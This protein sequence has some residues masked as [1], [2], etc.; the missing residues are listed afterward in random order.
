MWVAI[1]L[2]ATLGTNSCADLKR[3][4]RESQC[5]KNPT[6]QLDVTCTAATPPWAGRAYSGYVH[7]WETS[8][9]NRWTNKTVA[10]S[11]LGPL[12]GGG[13]FV[14]FTYQFSGDGRRILRHMGNSLT[15]FEDVSQD[16]LTNPL[17]PFEVHGNEVRPLYKEGEVYAGERIVQYPD[18]PVRQPFYRH[19]GHRFNEDFS[20]MY[21]RSDPDAHFQTDFGLEFYYEKNGTS[22]NIA[23]QLE[24][25]D[26][27]IMDPA[28]YNSTSPPVLHYDPEF[29]Q[30]TPTVEELTA[31]HKLS[32]LSVQWDPKPNQ[33]KRNRPW[34]VKP[35]LQ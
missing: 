13:V 6:A 10:D 21:Y 2:T 34:L 35:P 7:I 23:L 31:T 11:P 24:K 5:C 19:P 32:T 16:F 33:P 28:G 15:S 25:F 27:W 3:L 30:N 29:T 8:L 17:I 26:E 22:S 20:T 14:K 18:G 9:Y 4:F 1:A 12:F